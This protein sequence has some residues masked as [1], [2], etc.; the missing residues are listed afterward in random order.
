[1]HFDKER[2]SGGSH[3]K[4]TDQAWIS[5]TI[6]FSLVA[7]PLLIVPCAQHQTTRR[8]W[9]IPK[10]KGVRMDFTPSIS[11]PRGRERVSRDAAIERSWNP[12]LRFFDAGGM[13]NACLVVW[14][15]NYYN[16]RVISIYI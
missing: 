14:S 15:H 9:R 3:S 8:E 1:M 6:F 11:Y 16:H 2:A 12:S 13:E 5:G 10:M 7:I 4:L